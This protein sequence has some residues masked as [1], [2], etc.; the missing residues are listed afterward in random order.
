MT[1]GYLK[2]L[3][4][5]EIKIEIEIWAAKEYEN[6]NQGLTDSFCKFFIYSVKY[7]KK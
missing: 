4:L 7:G 2:A 6:D 5:P 3:V 1:I